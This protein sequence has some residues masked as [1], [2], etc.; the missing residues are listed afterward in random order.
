MKGVQR[1]TYLD[2]ALPDTDEAEIDAVTETIRSGWLTTGPKTRAF[3]AEFARYVGAKHAVAVNSCTA[4]MHLALEAIEL[5]KGDEVITTPY[6][7]AATGEVI[8]YFDAVPRF[9]DVEPC[10]LTIDPQQVEAAITS[11][12]RA[13]IPVHLAGHPAEMESLLEIANR[14][15]VHIIE[16]AAHALPTLDNGRHIGSIGDMTCF[17]F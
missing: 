15:H 12:T 9:V 14:H 17:S 11:R 2:F 3:E 5:K 1:A 13:I 10:Y 6:T 8:R 4:A 7:F 16:D